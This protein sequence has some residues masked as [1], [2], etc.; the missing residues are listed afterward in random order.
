MSARG[1]PELFLETPVAWARGVWG[2]NSPSFCQDDAESLLKADAKI[3][4][5]RGGSNSSEK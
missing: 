1:R 4:G 3:N 2:A 5:G